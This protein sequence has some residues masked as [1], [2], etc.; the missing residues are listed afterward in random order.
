[1]SLPPMEKTLRKNEGKKERKKEKGSRLGK[2]RTHRHRAHCSGSKLTSTSGYCCA[3]FGLFKILFIYGVKCGKG[4]GRRCW[5]EMRYHQSVLCLANHGMSR[6][7]TSA[8]GCQVQ[9]FYEC[10]NDTQWGIW[11]VTHKSP[12]AIYHSKYS[13]ICHLMCHTQ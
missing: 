4:G 13:Y 5:L 10:G 6:I 9:S 1:M 11:S 12:L 3:L 2:K 8:T 7:I